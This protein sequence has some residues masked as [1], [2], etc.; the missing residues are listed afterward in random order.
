MTLSAT[1]AANRYADLPGRRLAYRVI[2]NGRPLLLAQR[3]R[4]TMDHWDPLFL[5]TLAALGFRVVVFDSSGI[6]RSTGEQTYAPPSLAR[7]LTEL[8][9]ALGLAQPGQPRPVLG[10]WSLGGIAAQLAFAQ[11]PTFWSHLVLLAT[12]PPGDIVKTGDPLFNDVATRPGEEEEDLITALFEPRSALSRAAAHRSFKRIAQRTEGRS[13][14]VPLGFAADYLGRTPR[15][16]PFPVPAVLETLR[17]T[18]T[19]ILH[20][21]GDHDLAFPVENWY[22]LGGQLPTLHLLTF[23]QAGHGPHL[24]EPEAAA[25]YIH[26]FV[27]TP[28]RE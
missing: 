3:F 19:P 16:P 4:G 1:Q 20:L 11:Q 8:A 23:P 15:T 25:H 24:Q 14:A 12:A 26:T 27:H 28:Y 22:A 2:G 13:P 21:G 10:G 17:T 9:Q 7:D 5:D 18:E 6:G